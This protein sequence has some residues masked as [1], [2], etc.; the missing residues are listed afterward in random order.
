MQWLFS[1]TTPAKSVWQLRTLDGKA[2]WVTALLVAG[3]FLKKNGG[4]LGHNDTHLW[5]QS[6]GS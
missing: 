1:W 2:L 5:F 4:W 3:V 6:L